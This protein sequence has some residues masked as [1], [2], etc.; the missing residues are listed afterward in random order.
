MLEN[1][2][3]APWQPALIEQLGLHQAAEAIPPPRFVDGRDRP[4]HLIGE[5]APHDGARIRILMPP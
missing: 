4:Q 5:F 1:L 2:A 3:R